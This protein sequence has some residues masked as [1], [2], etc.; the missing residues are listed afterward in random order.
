L[1]LI[2]LAALALLQQA[3]AADFLEVTEGRLPLVFAAPHGG[4]I[5]PEAWQVRRGGV[6]ARD[7]YTHEMGVALVE[8]I[9]LR[10]GKRPALVAS[11]AH[12]R[13]L[14]LNRSQTESGANYGD[15]QL[16]LWKSYHRAIEVECEKAR[17]VGQGEALFIDLHGHAHGHDFIELGFAISAT[18][19]RKPDTALADPEWVRGPKSLGARLD[20]VQLESVP[21][22]TR[23]APQLD[24]EYFSGG[25]SVR[26]H[27]GVGLRSIQIEL[28]R[29]KRPG[30]PED[31]QV[32]VEGLATATLGLLAD[33]FQLPPTV[34][35]VRPTAEQVWLTPGPSPWSAAVTRDLSCVV[36]DLPQSI[37]VFGLPVLGTQDVPPR[38][39]RSVA[40]AVAQALDPN[41]VGYLADGSTLHWLQN[42]G[43]FFAVVQ[44]DA[45]A[46][47][48]SAS[49]AAAKE[50]GWRRAVFVQ[51]ENLPDC[52]D[53]IPAALA[54]PSLRD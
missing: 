13:H 27:R 19:L 4:K 47:K 23:P 43:T 17:K 10:T 54:E 48:I 22:P 45:E 38:Q 24:E 14:D 34:E 5:R 41:S 30:K 39:L 3:P 32:I 7:M 37:E 31:R 6:H 20:A 51:A 2:C 53:Q 8:A 33:Q 50:A 12:R 36:K 15:A 26:R 35:E 16:E 44:N 46:R 28:S 49:I 11:L 9:R 21:S 40:Q 25:Y 18:D 52:L 1:S 29:R 42:R